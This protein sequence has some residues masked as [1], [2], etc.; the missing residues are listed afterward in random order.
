NTA[1][2]GGVLQVGDAANAGAT[3]ASTVDVIGGV[4]AGHG[5]VIG[6]VT[7]ESGGVLAPGGSIGTL[8]ISGSLTFNG[9]FYAVQITPVS[10]SATA[11][12]GGP[13]T[14][15]INDGIVVVIPQLGHYNA[16]TYTIVTAT[17]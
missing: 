3:L 14:A 17:G 10:N 7:I 11:V 2:N 12:N 13:G 1:V 8:T 16:T 4:L 9:G 15:T 5:T 6:D